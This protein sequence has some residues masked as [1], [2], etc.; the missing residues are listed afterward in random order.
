MKEIQMIRISPDELSELI[1]EKIGN[2]LSALEKSV[3]PQPEQ[4]LTREETAQLL[5][6]DKSTLWSWTK[7]G[8]LIAYGLG[9]R[10]YY[11]RSEIESALV[12]LNDGTSFL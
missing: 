8:K 7:K 1:S 4:F 10:V 2:R 3:A 12:Q 9:N 11:K 5:N 6:I